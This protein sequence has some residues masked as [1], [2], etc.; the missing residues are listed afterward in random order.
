MPDFNVSN[1][2]ECGRNNHDVSY[3]RA[4]M[5]TEVNEYCTDILDHLNK[6]QD[7]HGQILF[8][9]NLKEAVLQVME[10]EEEEIKRY[11]N[12]IT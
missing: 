4:Y 8:S 7:R 12:N 11:I 2:F 1:V 3:K 10:Q 9:K 6:Y 5:T